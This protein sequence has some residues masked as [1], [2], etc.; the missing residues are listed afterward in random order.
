MVDEEVAVDL[1]IVSSWVVWRDEHRGHCKHDAQE[2][3]LRAGYGLARL[4]ATLP[5]GRLE[6]GSK[7]AHDEPVELR[8]GGEVSSAHISPCSARARAHLDEEEV[9]EQLALVPGR[10]DRSQSCE[11]DR[12]G[13]LPLVGVRVCRVLGC[14][15][16]SRSE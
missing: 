1:E 3:P 16:Q 12:R 13:R 2:G 7:D 9:D 5:D 11:R 15:F 10:Q 8:T 4:E 14:P 6:P